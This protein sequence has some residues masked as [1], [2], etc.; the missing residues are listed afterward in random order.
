MWLQVLYFQTFGEPEAADGAMWRGTLPID[1]ALCGAPRL[2]SLGPYP[3][4]RH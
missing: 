1:W 4:Q 3:P 2:P